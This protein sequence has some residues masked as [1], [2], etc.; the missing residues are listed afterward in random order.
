M[1]YERRE[2]APSVEQF[3]WDKVSFSYGDF[4]GI[5]KLNLGD[6][7]LLEGLVRQQ[8]WEQKENKC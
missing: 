8:I 5:K 7:L 3:I 1:C 6:L 2:D 4:E